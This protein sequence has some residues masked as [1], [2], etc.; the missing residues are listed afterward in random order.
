MIC[1]SLTKSPVV[2]IDECLFHTVLIFTFGKKS[3]CGSIYFHRP[4][5]T[6]SLYCLYYT[7]VRDSV[8]A[9]Q[10]IQLFTLKLPLLC[11]QITTHLLLQVLAVL[12]FE[13]V[14]VVCVIVC[15]WLCVAC[16]VWCLCKCMNKTTCVCV[17]SVYTWVCVACTQVCVCVCVRRFETT[18]CTVWASANLDAWR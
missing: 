4:A 17:C 12:A 2:R 10:R 7:R 9:W 3:H 1:S 13:T 5:L 16:V 14:T 18:R 8:P 15:I 11:L 6:R